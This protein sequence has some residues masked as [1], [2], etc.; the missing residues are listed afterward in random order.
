M[1]QPLSPEQNKQLT[2]WAAQRDSILA[3]IAVKRTENEKLTATNK[4]LADSNTE[5]SNK[6]QQSIGRLAE[7]EK[8]EAARAS[9]TT[10]ENA[11][12]AKMKSVLQTEISSLKVE[13]VTL[14]ESKKGLRDD[15][16]AIT[17]IHEAVFNRVSDIERIIGATVTL[18]STNAQQVKNILIEAGIELKKIID[19]GAQN[20]EVTNRAIVQIPRIIMDLH[21][22]VLERRFTARHKVN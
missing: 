1:D 8:Q 12:L 6:V 4:D 18:N 5:I 2:A 22:D 14:F 15:I 19:I 11:E 3:E 17:K 7:L 16:E 21:K 20:V 13:V 10:V 9:L